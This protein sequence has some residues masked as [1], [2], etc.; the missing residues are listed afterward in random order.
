ML[1]IKLKFGGN[2]SEARDWMATSPL[3]QL[4]WN[5]TYACNYRCPICFTDSGAPSPGEL[6]FAEA[7]AMLLQA[8]AAGVRDIIISGGEPFMRA[9]LPDLLARM[10]ELGLTARI[11]SNG[12][13]VTDAL[14]D[15][16][17][18]ETRVKSFQ[19]SLDTLDAALYQKLHGSAPRS[20]E[21]ALAALDAIKAHGFHTTVSVRLTPETLPGIPAMLDAARRNGWSTVTIHC[22]LHTRRADGAFAQDDDVLTTLHPAL[23]HFC[24]IDGAWLI[25]TYIPWAPWHPAMRQL[26]KRF[27]V[28]HRGCRAGRDRLTVNPTGSVSPCVCLDVPPAHIGNV[29]QDDLSALFRDAPLCQIFRH[30]AEHGICDDCAHVAACGGGC[31]ASAYALTGHLDGPDGSCPVR[32][33]RGS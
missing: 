3:R 32:Q 5:V 9:D 26:E 2:H 10:A 16:L 23:E 25:E 7:E 31:R 19:I 18:R 1:D 8:K 13:L 22:P 6:A 15:R 11:A 29:R 17:R 4:F 24:E 12:S 20:L 30:P 28:V 21:R 14:L 33:A 27:R